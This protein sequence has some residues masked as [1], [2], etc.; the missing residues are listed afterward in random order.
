MNWQQIVV[1]IWLSFAA[2]TSILENG[3]LVTRS[4]TAGIIG[5]AIMAAILYTGGFWN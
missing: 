4:A 3:K 5:A 1:I 2:L